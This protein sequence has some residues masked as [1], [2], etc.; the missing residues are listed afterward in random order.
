[1]QGYTHSMRFGGMST[2]VTAQ[3]SALPPPSHQSYPKLMP[4]PEKFADWMSHHSHTNGLGHVYRYHPRSDAHSIALC[5]YILEDLIDACPLLRN[6]AAQG[7]VVYGINEKFTSPSTS[8]TKTL[9]LVLGPPAEPPVSARSDDS[10]AARESGGHTKAHPAPGGAIAKSAPAEVFVSCE[11]KSVMTEHAK[12]KP[13]VYDELSSSHQIVHQ[14]NPNAIAAGITVVNIAETFVSPLRQRDRHSLTVTPH[15]QPD[16]AAGM[17]QHL[18][19]L[20][21]RD[22]VGTVGFDAYASLVVDCDNQGGV[23]L[24]T[25]P[26][27][28][29]PGDR[30]HYETFLRRVVQFYVS[31]FSA[32]TDPDR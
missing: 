21:L 30:D 22:A 9:D 25:A 16:A 29:Q 23:T 15:R 10:P 14:G 7:L 28:P 4:A 27:A 32:I 1:M 26:P 18:R 24:W 5:T 31:R 20:P 17:I 19:G 2:P 11:A 13:R 6:Q 3:G 12:S 8:K